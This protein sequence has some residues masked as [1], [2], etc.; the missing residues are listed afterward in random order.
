MYI[1]QFSTGYI[2][3][4]KYTLYYR[5]ENYMRRQL[6]RNTY[7][8]E[9]VVVQAVVVVGVNLV[10]AMFGLQYIYSSHAH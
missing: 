10:H 2:F 8:C 5:L 7:S 1:W 9:I 6:Q 4:Y 3:P